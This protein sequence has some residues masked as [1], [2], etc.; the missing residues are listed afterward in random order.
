M[1]YIL[2]I[3]AQ[4]AFKVALI[5]SEDILW[6]IFTRYNYGFSKH[7]NINLA[8]LLFKIMHMGITVGILVL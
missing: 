4:R 7:I 8:Q 6:Y 2:P 5:V 3:K 1:I